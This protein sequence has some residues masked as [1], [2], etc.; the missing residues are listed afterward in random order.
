MPTIPSEH[1][2]AHE[3]Q[4][5]AAAEKALEGLTTRQEKTRAIASLLFF[6]YGIFPAYATVRKYTNHG[7]NSDINADLREFWLDLQQK[8]RVKVDSP[9]PSALNTALGEIGHKLW[10]HAEELAQKQFDVDRHILQIQIHGLK[11]E[12]EQRDA[13]RGAA[14]AQLKSLGEEFAAFEAK[15]KDESTYLLNSLDAANARIAQFKEE[16][17]KQA[18]ELQ[19]EKGLRYLAQERLV[20]ELT[21]SAASREQEAKRYQADISHVRL[22]LDEAR[23]ETKQVQK[24]L[25]KVF[26]ERDDLLTQRNTAEGDCARLRESI[27]AK[28]AEMLDINKRLA[29][30]ERT[31]DKKEAPKIALRKAVKVIRKKL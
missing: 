27:K 5:Q 20:S 21:A 9:L 10:L 30:M 28:D 7:S 14:E 11:K 3:K 26:A 13:W 19:E 6:N 2:Q 22:Q 24:T 18:D 25:E 12:L 1:E 8:G 29:A 31:K 4:I 16:F 23:T 17:A 15:A